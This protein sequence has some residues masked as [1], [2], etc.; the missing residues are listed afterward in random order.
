MLGSYSQF[1]EYMGYKSKSYVNKLKKEG[2][3]VFVGGQIDFEKSKARINGT[4]DIAR[5]NI[6]DKQRQSSPPPNEPTG[7]PAGMSA[8]QQYDLSK[9][10]EKIWSAK[11][12][13]LEYERRLGKLGSL[14]QIQKIGFDIGKIIKTRFSTFAIRA[15]PVVTN[16]TSEK[17]NREYLLNE[18]DRIMSEVMEEVNRVRDTDTES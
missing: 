17:A 12:K 16:E 18:V 1:C 7:D 4:A 11:S 5:E 3:L 10:A 14:D 8:K 13:K 15:A 2:R 6:T 9:T